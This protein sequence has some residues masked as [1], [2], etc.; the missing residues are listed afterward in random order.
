MDELV[1]TEA[2]EMGEVVFYHLAPELAFPVGPVPEDVGNFNYIFI[3]PLHDDFK[4]YLEPLW[5]EI[6]SLD[7]LSLEHEKT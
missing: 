2:P 3:S 7:N 5:L 6:H 4:A 1:D